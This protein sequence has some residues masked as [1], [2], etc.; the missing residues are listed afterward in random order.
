METRLILW[1]TQTALR[2][3]VSVLV[4]RTPDCM[5]RPTV[6]RKRLE[7]VLAQGHQED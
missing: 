7:G 6:E 5:I 3:Q 2:V 1:T 4:K